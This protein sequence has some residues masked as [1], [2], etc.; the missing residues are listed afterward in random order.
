VRRGG[1]VPRTSKQPSSG[2]GTSESLAELGF[3]PA[4]SSTT[5]A[6][7]SP[8]LSLASASRRGH[9]DFWMVFGSIHKTSQWWPSRS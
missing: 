4:R 2:F 6:E 3:L 8:S 7:P 9:Y 5:S 1:D